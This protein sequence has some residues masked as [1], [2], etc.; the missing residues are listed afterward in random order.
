M[1][2]NVS[3]DNNIIGKHREKRLEIKILLQQDVQVKYF[4]PA[5]SVCVKK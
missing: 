1:V 5:F 2:I 4:S 3:L